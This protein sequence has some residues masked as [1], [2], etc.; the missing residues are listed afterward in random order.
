MSSFLV[1]AIGIFVVLGLI[2]GLRI[3]AFIALI[4]AALV[5]SF[6]AA[7]PASIDGQEVN[8]ITLKERLERVGREF[9]TSAGKDWLG[10]WVRGCHWRSDDA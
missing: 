7:D 3:N 5:V 4:V 6:L 10:D 8:P 2:I 1:V 9:G